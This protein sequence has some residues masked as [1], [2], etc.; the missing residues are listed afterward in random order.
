V[1]AA[2]ALVVIARIASADP[3][4]PSS[5]PPEAG[6]R[7]TP[8]PFVDVMLGGANSGIFHRVDA[9]YALRTCDRGLAIGANVVAADIGGGVDGAGLDVEPN[10]RTSLQTRLG[11]FVAVDRV[12]DSRWLYTAEVRLHLADTFWFEAGAYHQSSEPG[13]SPGSVPSAKTGVV[14]GF[15]VEGKAGWYVGG[16]ELV[17]AGIAFAYIAASGGISG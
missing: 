4:P 3:P 11:L 13:V 16:V 5:A 10:V 17:L 12:K 7:C 8:G 1:R 2:L 15:G 14:A 6:L 9:G